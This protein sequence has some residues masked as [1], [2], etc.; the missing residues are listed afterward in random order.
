VSTPGMRVHV[1]PS[2]EAAA[3]AAATEIA[4][5]AGAAVVDRWRF[6]V[7]VSGGRTPWHM[8]A[9]LAAQDMPW[10]GTSIYQVDERIG[11]ADDPARNLIGLRRALPPEGVDRVIP[12]PVENSDL[13]GA[14]AAYAEV[15]PERFD[16]VHLGLG[17]DG[18]TA[19]LVPGDPVL[20]VADADVAVTGVYQDRRRMTLTYPPIDRARAVL[21]LVTGA[22]K[23][24]AL[25]QLRS[26]DQGIPAG[27]VRTEEQVLFCDAEAAGQQG[28]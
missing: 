18:H 6:T 26:G 22:D 19:S 2:A 9:A 25:V 1:L 23:Q 15:L 28:R 5:R 17:P 11:P 7:A 13:A 12:M 16:V 14:C 24:V 10:A 27:R 20:S 21:W 8:L 4:R 3:R